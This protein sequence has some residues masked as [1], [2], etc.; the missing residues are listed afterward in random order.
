MKIFKNS[1]LN[2]I[3]SKR[4]LRQQRRATNRQLIA[5]VKLR[6]GRA[7]CGRDLPLRNLLFDHLNSRPEA[8][9]G[10][11]MGS[12]RASELQQA[13]PLCRLFSG[14]EHWL[15]HK[16]RQTGISPAACVAF[17]SSRGKDLK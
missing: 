14:A 10:F 5:E 15:L 17:A 1:P 8:N 16:A 2:R 11:Q 12:A 3:Q 6:L 7:L 13:L 9:Q 4:L